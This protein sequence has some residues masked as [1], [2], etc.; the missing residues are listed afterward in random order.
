LHPHTQ[1]RICKNT[2]ARTRMHTQKYNRIVPFSTPKL[3]P[4]K[5]SLETRGTGTHSYPRNLLPEYTA[6]QQIIVILTK[7]N[8]VNQTNERIL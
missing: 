4:L 7:R 6:S 5:Q 2:H 1:T 8:L 3:P